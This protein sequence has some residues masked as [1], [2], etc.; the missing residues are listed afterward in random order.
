MRIFLVTKK[1]KVFVFPL[2]KTMSLKRLGYKPYLNIGLL[3]DEV[4]DFALL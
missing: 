4:L 2:P 3:D 1:G